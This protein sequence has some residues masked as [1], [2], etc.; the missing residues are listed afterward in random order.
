MILITDKK[1][2][3]RIVE[4]LQKAVLGENPIV[5]K[6]EIQG[7][8]PNFKD[9][10]GET[11]LHQASKNGR[12]EVVKHLIAKGTDPNLK[13]NVFNDLDFAECDLS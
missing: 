13:N 8:D 6:I 1:S 4:L 7:A 12:L 9:E 5:C 10:K 11:A 2:K 3:P